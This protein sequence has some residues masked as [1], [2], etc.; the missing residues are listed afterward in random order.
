MGSRS[1]SGQAG[2]HTHPRQD[3]RA[4]A[5]HRESNDCH[6]EVDVATVGEK[7]SEDLVGAASCPIKYRQASSPGGETEAKN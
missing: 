4:G 1:A 2:T 7:K 6:T 3:G 5:G